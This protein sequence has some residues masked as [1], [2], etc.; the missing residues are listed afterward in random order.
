VVRSE[1]QS[2]QRVIVRVRCELVKIAGAAPIGKSRERRVEFCDWGRIELSRLTAFCGDLGEEVLKS[3]AVFLR[4]YY[5]N[6]HTQAGFDPF[7]EAIHFDGSVGADMCREART[8]PKR[9]AGFDEHA[10]GTD[11][12]CSG[13]EDGGAPFDLEIGTVVVALSPASLQSSWMVATAHDW[14]FAPSCE[15]ESI[16]V[17]EAQSQRFCWGEE[18]AKQMNVEI[19]LSRLGSV[20]TT[21]KEPIT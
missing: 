10:V 6:A 14:P 5:G 9:V 18:Y 2:R 11:I 21:S 1:P 12:T 4:H 19:K 15:P 8:D 20:P 16:W 3:L 7:D 17:V 13:A